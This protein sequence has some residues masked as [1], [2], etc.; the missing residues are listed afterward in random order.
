MK[1]I[2]YLLPLVALTLTALTACEDSPTNPA[3]KKAALTAYAWKTV[4]Q[5]RGG[6]TD[7]NA[8]SRRQFKSDNT[9]TETVS[10][11]VANGTWSLN[12]DETSVAITLSGTTTDWSIKT[13][14]S[15]GIELET[16]IGGQ[17]VVF[18]GEPE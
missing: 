7:P 18:K 8:P 14:T 2:R 12:V 17:S 1:A 6:V 11:V 13:L 3:D 5:T 15:S 4:S 10:G 9:Y 16:N